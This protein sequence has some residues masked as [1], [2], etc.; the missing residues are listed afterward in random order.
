MLGVSQNSPIRS[1]SRTLI[2]R[3][4]LKRTYGARGRFSWGDA[5]CLKNARILLANS[6]CRYPAILSLANREVRV[7]SG[8]TPANHAVTRARFIAPAVITC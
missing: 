7:S 3:R 2:S 1:S 8:G 5:F 4:V 6:P